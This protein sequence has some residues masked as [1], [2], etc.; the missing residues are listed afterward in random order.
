MEPIP[1]HCGE[2]LGCFHCSDTESCG[3]WNDYEYG[4]KYIVWSEEKGTISYET[5]SKQQA[6]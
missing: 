2:C 4:E 1:T 6:S 3:C 5:K